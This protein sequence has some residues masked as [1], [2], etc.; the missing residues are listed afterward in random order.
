MQL[1]R[2]GNEGWL[3]GRRIAPLPLL[4]MSEHILHPDPTH[5]RPSIRLSA[6]CLP[7]PPIIQ[8]L[9]RH[10]PPTAALGLIP[11]AH[12]SRQAAGGSMYDAIDPCSPHRDLASKGSLLILNHQSGPITK[13]RI[14]NH[15]RQV[16]TVISLPSEP[17][18]LLEIHSCWLWNR[19]EW[20]SWH[21]RPSIDR[22]TV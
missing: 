9:F 13:H 14:T 2:W 8:G 1:L 20:S 15:P 21:P 19:T 6:L 12:R 5:P 4:I 11:T 3:A 16:V 10:V 7:G 22:A 18:C 17:F